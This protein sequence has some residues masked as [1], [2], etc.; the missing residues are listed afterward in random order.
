[1]SKV[2]KKKQHLK[3][4]SQSAECIPY[5]SVTK[6][7][8]A[9]ETAPGQFSRTYQLSENTAD[10][11]MVT[12]V[13]QGLPRDIRIQ[14]TV[15][16]DPSGY[17]RYVSFSVR[18]MTVEQ[19]MKSLDSAADKF[20]LSLISMSLT[21]Q[22]GI[23]YRFFN[24]Y[25]PGNITDKI[26]GQDISPS[27]LSKTRLTTKD[28]VGSHKIRF[29][30][31]YIETDG[32]FVRIFHIRTLSGQIPSGILNGMLEAGS[33]TL[34]SLHIEPIDAQAV[35]DAINQEIAA[36]RKCAVNRK[37]GKDISKQAKSKKKTL[38]ELYPN[39]EEIEVKEAFTSI[40]KDAIDT[41]RDLYRL[42]FF[43]AVFSRSLEELDAHTE[44]ILSHESS[45][46][47]KAY[48]C[49]YFQK[50][51]IGPVLPL[52]LDVRS[53]SKIFTLST[54]AALTGTVMGFHVPVDPIIPENDKTCYFIKAKIDKPKAGGSLKT[55]KTIQET[56]PYFAAYA[57]D[58]IIETSPGVFTKMYR[59]SD[60][61]YH[62]ATEEDQTGFLIKYS[63]LLNR[64][65][66]TVRFQVVLNNKNVDM[67]EFK[68][69]NLLK[70]KGDGL[71]VYRK[72]YNALLLAKMEEGRNN[73]KRERYL[74]VSIEAENLDAAKHSFARLDPEI[75]NSF[76]E[77]GGSKAEPLTTEER[78][79]VLYDIYNI[80]HEGTFLEEVKDLES[81]YRMGIPSKDLIAPSGFHFRRDWLRMGPKYCRVLYLMD[82][83]NTL[84]DK[85][86]SELSSTSCNMILSMNLEAVRQDKAVKLVKHQMLNIN[87]SMQQAQQTAS[88][89]GYSMDLVPQDLRQAQEEA[90]DLLRNLT[91][92]NQKMFLMTF[93]V[94][95]FADDLDELH[96]NTET[97][98]STGRK[99]LCNLKKLQYQ[100]EDG[101]NACL[102]LCVNK[103]SVKRTLTTDSTIIFSPFDT[104]EL[105][106][107]KGMYYGQNATSHNLILFSRDSSQN[108]NGWILGTP[109]SGKSF[110][111]KMEMANV[112]LNTDDDIL[113]IDPEREYSPLVKAFGGSI[114]RIAPGSKYH[115]NPLDM[116]KDYADDDDPIV[117]KSDFM[118]SLCESVIGGRY[119]LTPTQIAI[120][121]RC[122]NLIYEEFVAKWDYDKAYTPTLLDF[123]HVLE[124]Q[125][126]RE[127][128]ELALAFE[129][130]TKGSLDVFAHESNVDIKNRFVVYD[131]KDIGSN[132]KTMAYLIVLDAI[133]NRVVKNRKIG[134]KTWIY[135]DEVY[136][137]FDKDESAN[138]IRQIF[139]RGRKWGAR[140]TAITQNVEPILQNTIA[141]TM[142]SNSAFIQLL[143]QAPVD[144]DIL[145]NL[146][147]ISPT[148]TNFI[149]TAP[150]GQ[151]ILY[152]QD[153]GIIPFRNNFS[154][155]IAPNMYQIMTS[156]PDE[157]LEEFR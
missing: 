34:L 27:I 26:N 75:I 96:T 146:L 131:I 100:Q 154:R 24:H 18:A 74:V 152:I 144:R 112:F 70:P 16:H 57:K 37:S 133:W 33:N 142:L 19:A 51:A 60:I 82:L 71:D 134:K 79:E 139:S 153:K 80:G 25:T 43:T 35:L 9:I 121:D 76:K 151:G 90:N 10:V 62:T 102:P 50:K 141:T 137:L 125:P 145:S 20:P 23:I 122:V 39:F 116:D 94:L 155:H 132:I 99:F 108:G 68:D 105:I 118:L 13:L 97:L 93:T 49:D 111:A 1:M 31:D 87:S 95:V 66:S 28:L 46:F 65:D 56:I 92:R 88:K 17:T 47:L 53:Y 12:E 113:I 11:G 54:S 58:G 103:L 126:E 143:N 59:F 42:S 40:L 63:Q 130:Y 123:E 78:L 120:I 81:M 138:Y 127:A 106:Q 3:I 21:E 69:E 44:E 67:V 77:I 157:M 148:Q 114:V 8:N 72:E 83:P 147:K 109:G 41:S 48:P 110:A 107:K 4:P 119:G 7:G 86:V 64:F 91:G 45:S 124:A 129:I 5:L 135:M 73:L 85:F 98:I 32:G 115:L 149:S 140:V 15:I 52:V 117:L 29:D 36:Y 22:L 156:K 101:L 84:S 150:P 38:Q 104:Q 30:K 14:V 128:R 55:K 2:R 61:N 136:L 89:N 6:E